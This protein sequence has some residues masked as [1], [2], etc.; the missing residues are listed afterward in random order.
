[1]FGAFFLLQIDI[2]DPNFAAYLTT[3]CEG[4]V[5]FDDLA[6]RLKKAVL[7]ELCTRP[8]VGLTEVRRDGKDNDAVTMVIT[9]H[10]Y[11]I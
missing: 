4:N 11:M 10:F 1:M 5:I 2:M 9:K 8:S 6:C 7:D 3:S